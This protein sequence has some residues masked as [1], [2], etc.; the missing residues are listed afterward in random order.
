[1]EVTGYLNT[2]CIGWPKV[3]ERIEPFLAE[4][5]NARLFEE[6]ETVLRPRFF[7]LE[8]AVASHYVQ[9]PKTE[10]MDLRPHFIDFALMPECRAL[11]D[12]PADELV[13]AADLSAMIPEL[14]AQWMAARKEEICAALEQQLGQTQDNIFE[15]ATAAFFC[16]GDCSRALLR[17]PE[18]LAHGCTRKTRKSVARK[19]FDQDR[20]EYAFAASMHKTDD[21]VKQRTWDSRWDGTCAPF[22]LACVTK[23]EKAVTKA[24]RALRAIVAAMGLD[25]DRATL[26]ELQACEKRLLCLTC[27]RKGGDNAKYAYGWEAAV[28]GQS[29]RLFCFQILIYSR[30]SSSILSPRPQLAAVASQ[31]VTKHGPPFEAPAIRR[32]LFNWKWP[33][34]PRLIRAREMTHD[35]SGPVP[36]VQNG[37]R[38]G[39]P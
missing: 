22:S 31:E 19:V 39:K 17:Y 1:M 32:E 7:E 16:T 18:I 15:L 5:R 28:S 3:R 11:I 27:K 14:G 30:C 36:C 26:A 38:S 13:T 8:A 4:T 20:D 37:A 24:T 9:L 12:V 10:S 21:S 2:F 35:W 23:D 6:H 25:P 29:L 34:K 33:R